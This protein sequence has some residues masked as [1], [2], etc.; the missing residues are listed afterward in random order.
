ME[1]SI[2]FR[3]RLIFLLPAFAATTPYICRYDTI[4][5]PLRH[6]TFSATTPYIFRYDTI[7]L[8][9][10]HHTF[11]ATTPYICRYDTVHSVV[12]FAA[13]HQNFCC[14][15]LKKET[16]SSAGSLLQGIKTS[17]ALF[18]ARRQRT[19]AAYI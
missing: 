2:A 5:L 18:V 15:N 7:H 13:T 19:S 3:T 16:R 14:L 12:S 1:V 4:H 6:H 17:P 8:P 9:L 11:A 10:R